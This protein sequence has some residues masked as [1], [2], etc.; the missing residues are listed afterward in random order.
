MLCVVGNAGGGGGRA[1]WRLPGVFLMRMCALAEFVMHAI[2]RVCVCIV[3]MDG[4]APSDDC[5]YDLR[6]K[7]LQLL[8]FVLFLLGFCTLRITSS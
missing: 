3:G 8:P 4:G 2:F 1:N 5:L 7:F 6:M